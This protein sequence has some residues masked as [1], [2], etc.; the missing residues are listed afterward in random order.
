VIA[1]ADSPSSLVD[2][3]GERGGAATDGIVPAGCGLRR[4]HSSP[5]A[6]GVD[7]ARRE[8]DRAVDSLRVIGS[9][10]KRAPATA[11]ADAWIVANAIAGR[12]ASRRAKAIAARSARGRAVGSRVA[13]P[14]ER[15]PERPAAAPDG[16]AS[17]L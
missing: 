13:W 3:S 10:A 9:V 16:V 6:R 2:P 7:A 15:G 11:P 4:R 1:E 14:A 8:R 17:R 12:E 5:P